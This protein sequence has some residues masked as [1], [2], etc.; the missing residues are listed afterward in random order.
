[1]YRWWAPPRCVLHFSL[2]FSAEVSVTNTYATALV[3][4]PYQL[5]KPPYKTCTASGRTIVCHLTRTHLTRF[6]P[7]SWAFLF[8]LVLF[9]LLFPHFLH[10]YVDYGLIYMTFFY[11]GT[12]VWS[13]LLLL[14]SY[15]IPF[16][17]KTNSLT[18][19]TH[20]ALSTF[21]RY[22]QNKDLK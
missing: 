7:N 21:D 9:C 13:L 20:F 5:A 14:L 22:T 6:S 4:Q 3:S 10:A 17:L 2:I 16:S 1:M 8:V 18:L 12:Q 15:L 11:Y 19:S